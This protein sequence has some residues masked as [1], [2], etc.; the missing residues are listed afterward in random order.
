MGRSISRFLGCWNA[1]AWVATSPV[2]TDR[3]LGTHP[4]L[5][6]ILVDRNDD[7]SGSFRQC[8]DEDPARRV[9][10][11]MFLEKAANQKQVASQL[12]T[13]LV[14][15]GYRTILRCLCLN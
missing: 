1:R 6:G 13:T 11:S 5:C 4:V 12:R 9:C 10:D 15:L 7:S 2:V 8:A 14:T 3:K